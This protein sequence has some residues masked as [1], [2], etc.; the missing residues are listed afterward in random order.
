MEVFVS[1]REHAIKVSLSD[2]EL[3]ILD[4]HRGTT[5]RAAYMRQL[6]HGPPRNADVAT[7]AEAMS[8]LTGLARDGRQQA[9][10]ALARELREGGDKVDSW[11]WIMGSGDGV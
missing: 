2:D 4:E 11:G 10:V 1:H 7:R 3:A 8:I 5:T 6:L 9:A